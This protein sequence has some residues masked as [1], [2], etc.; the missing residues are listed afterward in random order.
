MASMKSTFIGALLSACS[1]A[2]GAVPIADSIADF[3]TVQG[4]NGWSYG[5]FD[6][7]AAPGAA[8]TTSAF[9]E[10]AGFNTVNSR[11]EASDAQVGANNN[12]FLSLNATGGH[13]NG[14]GPGDQNSIIWAVRRYTSE[15]AG[16]VDIS[17]L[18]RKNNISN[19]DGGGITGHLFVDGA[20][21]L[22]Q[23]VENT[24]GVGSQGSFTVAVNIGSFIDL[25]IDP[26]GV[27]SRRDASEFSA[28]ADGSD[29]SVQINP[30]GIPEPGS[31][32]LLLA[33]APGLWRNRR[34]R[35]GVREFGV[36][37]AIPAA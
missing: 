19:P 34:R 17:Y 16:L 23:F 8:Y 14:I 29:F 11:W 20:E 9:V 30:P 35:A 26:K 36:T 24:D 22:N 3:S 37:S 10:F 32:L 6:A 27:I 15:V 33:A 31:A 12:D 1:L 4:A 2:A 7:G 28:R 25:A 5:F 18:L 21:L 13:P